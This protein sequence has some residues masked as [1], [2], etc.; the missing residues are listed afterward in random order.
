MCNDGFGV[1]EGLETL[2]GPDVVGVPPPGAYGRLFASNQPSWQPSRH[3]K[4]PSRAVAHLHG[5]GFQGNAHA[6]GGYVRR[7]QSVRMGCGAGR[8][9][10]YRFWRFLGMPAQ[11]RLSPHANHITRQFLKQCIL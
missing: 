5:T 11:T 9:G 3:W 8:I 6:G 7:K 4:S 10:L 2:N 1:R